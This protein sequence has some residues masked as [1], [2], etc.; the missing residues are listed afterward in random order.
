NTAKNRKDRVSSL[1]GERKRASHMRVVKA[2]AAPGP[3]WRVR[4][5][6]RLPG[7]DFSGG[8]RA[9]VSRGRRRGVTMW[10]ARSA[11]PDHHAAN[12]RPGGPA[13]GRGEVLGRHLPGGLT[14]PAI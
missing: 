10:Q 3:T 12:R 6:T 2:I 11:S 4:D 1:I 5:A 14:A 9:P 13:G 7:G 8:G